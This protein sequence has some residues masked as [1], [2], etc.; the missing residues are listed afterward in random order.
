MTFEVN[1]LDVANVVKLR[2]VQTSKKTSS[3]QVAKT[4]AGMSVVTASPSQIM[5]LNITAKR[6]SEK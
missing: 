6:Q 3:Q 1:F 4:N 5:G 2:S